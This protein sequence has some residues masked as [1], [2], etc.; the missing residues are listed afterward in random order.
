[1]KQCAVR[2]FENE[3]MGRLSILANRH[4]RPPAPER[5]PHSRPIKILKLYSDP[6]AR[7]RGGA[8]W[9]LQL[10]TTAAGSV[11]LPPLVLASLPL[12]WDQR[13]KSP[14]EE[15]HPMPCWPCRAAVAG[16]QLVARLSKSSWV[17]LQLQL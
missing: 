2:Q 13:T 5:G 8:R 1:M 7:A 12:A 10:G 17:S 4:L 6:P 14:K 3:L 9:S 16:I 15:H 11:T